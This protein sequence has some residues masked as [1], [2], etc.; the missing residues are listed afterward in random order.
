MEANTTHRN[1]LAMVILLTLG[2]L[3]GGTTSLARFVATAGVPPLGYALWV[4]AGAGVLLIA[5][6]LLR[7]LYFPLNPV[8]LRY[9]LTCGLIGSAV[10][11][12]TMIF[13]LGR[14][15]AGLMAIILS[16]TPLFTYCFALA[17]RQERFDTRRAVG[18]SL[19]FA[20]AALIIA[21]QGALNDTTPIF[22]VLLA[23]LTPA[24][25]AITNLFANRYR[26]PGAHSLVL[27]AG[28]MFS[29][30]VLLTPVVWLT[31]Q[32]HPLWV[33]F[34]LADG[35]ILVHIGTA[36]VAFLLFF[37][38]LRLAGPV[39]VSQV[40]YLVTL[41]GVSFGIWIFD[42]RHSNWVWVA[43]GLILAG[44]ALVNAEQ[45]PRAAH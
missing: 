16:S 23:F 44:V 9:Y 2:L 39:F 27:A 11:T 42:E 35:L 36:A 15:P 34:D 37:V 12:T 21:P 17:F 31:G 29:A 26:P 13:V 33:Q 6:G 24:G 25:Y 20:G 45:K 3:W 10:P 1:S 14:I 30:G 18:I 28:M 8:Y 7:G 32:F 5:I 19:G 4:T 41:S 22:F 40:G 38:V 43:L